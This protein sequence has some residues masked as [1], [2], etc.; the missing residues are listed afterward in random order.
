MIHRGVDDMLPLAD[1]VEFLTELLRDPRAD[2]AF[3]AD[4]DGTLA[5]R[6]LRDVS[7]QDVRDVRLFLEGCGV[8][9]RE[10]LDIVA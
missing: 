8:A 7:A 10:A 3:A 9:P 2:A 1:L 6:G 4:P 5:T